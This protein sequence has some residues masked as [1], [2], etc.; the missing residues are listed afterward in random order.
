MKSEYINIIYVYVDLPLWVAITCVI[1]LEGWQ[2]QILNHINALTALIGN[3]KELPFLSCIHSNVKYKWNY[4]NGIMFL[5][6]YTMQKWGWTPLRMFLV[7]LTLLF[8]K[9]YRYSWTMLQ[10]HRVFISTVL[11]KYRMGSR[12]RPFRH[13]LKVT[14]NH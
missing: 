5:I 12:P 14:I 6:R 4:N 9:R 7:H 1:C 13:L 2:L 11:I 10:E 3:V 8:V